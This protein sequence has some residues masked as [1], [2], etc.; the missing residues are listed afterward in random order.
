[1]KFKKPTITHSYFVYELHYPNGG[2]PFYVGYG[3]RDRADGGF[4]PDDHLSEVTR[5]KKCSN[6]QKLNVI[7]K[8]FES[9]NEPELRIVFQSDDKNEALAEEVRRISLYGRRD[10]RTGSL[11]NLTIGGD[12][13]SWES[14]SDE[15]KAEIRQKIKNSLADPS[16]RSKIA[17]ATRQR[18]TGQKDSNETIEKRVKAS[19][20]KTAN[21][22]P[23]NGM[24]GRNHSIEARERMS[25]SK[26][27]RKEPEHVTKARAVYLKNLHMIKNLEV[28]RNI[29]HLLDQGMLCKHITRQLGVSH[30]TVTKVRKERLLII[31]LL[32]ERDE[33]KEQE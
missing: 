19:R 4:R 1:M 20:G 27:G 13:S 21:E 2:G 7:R 18:R 22:G 8:I 28:Y 33:F 30:D 17:N 29:I 16:I 25:F 5:P 32:K 9:G 11:V 10:N 15:K 31:E 3:K 23:K 12:G 14:F 26:R 6:H 24:F